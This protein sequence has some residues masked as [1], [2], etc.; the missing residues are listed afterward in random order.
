ME[1]LCLEA[2][3]LP[4]ADTSGRGEVARIESGD[5]GR[6]SQLT[7][8]PD[9][10]PHGARK[11]KQKRLQKKGETSTAR[12]V[13]PQ[14]GVPNFRQLATALTTVGKR[15]KEENRCN[16][17]E[18]ELTSV[19]SQPTN[20]LAPQNVAVAQEFDLHVVLP[21]PSSGIHLLLNNEGESVNESISESGEDVGRLDEEANSLIAIQK[22][23]GFTFENG[24]E[25]IQSKLVELEK[26]DLK[27]KIVRE[28]RGVDQ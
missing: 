23:V 21:M 15:R 7:E 18:A 16:N 28:Q 8:P 3:I 19:P 25:E 22:E 26:L 10:L 6:S 24:E 20:S 5:I 1:V 14:L 12:Q 11:T 9:E 17:P 27:K 2:Q 4:D 13:P